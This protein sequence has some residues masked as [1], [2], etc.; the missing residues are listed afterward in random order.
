MKYIL[1][2]VFVIFLNQNTKA[3]TNIIAIQKDIDQTVWKPFQ[4]AFETL[5]AKALNAIYADKTLRATPE[6]IDTNEA[7]KSN[8]IEAFKASEKGGVSMQLDF[9]FDDRK[10]NE[11]TSYEVGFYRIRATVNGNVNDSYGQFH[12]VLKKLNGIWKITQDWDTTIINGDA[13]D[14]EDFEKQMPLKF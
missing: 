4:K 5:D 11:T 1:Y 9:W 13:I 3:Q 2:I 14:K 8:N 12:I 6:G 7:Y 10:T